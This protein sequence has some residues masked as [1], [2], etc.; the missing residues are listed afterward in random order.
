M[1]RALFV[2]ASV[3]L[4][5]ACGKKAQEQPAASTAAAPAPNQRKIDSAIAKSGLPMTS[6]VGR[7]MSSA[8]RA[9]ARQDSLDKLLR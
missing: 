5:G 7:A 8:D 9:T 6:A 2:A 1:R 3:L 4:L